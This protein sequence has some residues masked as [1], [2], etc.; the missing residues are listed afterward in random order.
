MNAR[1]TLQALLDGKYI[2][3][4]NWDNPEDKV[5]LSDDGSSLVYQDGY[6]CY[7]PFASGLYE[8]VGES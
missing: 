2:R 4:V 8:V 5:R 1:E 7:I 6:Q 3:G